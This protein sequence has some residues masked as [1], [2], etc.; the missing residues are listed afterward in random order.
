MNKILVIDDSACT[1]RQMGEILRGAG[2]EVLEAPDGFGGLDRLATDD[3]DCVVFD[4]TLR[5]MN[6]Q[7]FVERLHREGHELPVVV[8]GVES[9]A[10]S[11]KECDLLGAAAY[12]AKPVEP[13]LLIETIERAVGASEWAI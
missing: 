13:D 10:L 1:R 8:T 7:T 3:L 5:S 4:L 11:R 9:V 12:L 6:A 2:F